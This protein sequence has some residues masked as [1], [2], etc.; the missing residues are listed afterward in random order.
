MESMYVKSPL[1]TAVSWANN[2][3][4]VL[5]IFFIWMIADKAAA[6]FKIPLSGGVLGLF[7]LVVLLLTNI[8]RPGYIEKGAELL[9]ANMLLYFI[10]LVV[11]VIQYT[12]LFQ[13]SGVKLMIAICVG[14]VVVMI[15]TAATVEWF[16]QWTRRR[17]L[18]S[19]ITARK[20]RLIARHHGQVI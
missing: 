20:Q 13:S 7:I 8:V 17:L 1:N 9:L 10:P 11:S 19:H 5:I 6:L 18:Q 16:C 4:Q 12:A 3:G 14:F 15:V 2:L